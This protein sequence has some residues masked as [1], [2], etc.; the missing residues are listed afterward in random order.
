MF[1]VVFLVITCVVVSAHWYLWRRLVRDVSAPGGWWRRTGTV[2][3]F[4]MPALLV[5]AMVTTRSDVPFALQRTLAWPG[6]MWFAVVVYLLLTLLVLEVVRPLVLRLL[7]RR[8]A[9]RAGA[10]GGER[11]AAE[12]VPAALPTTGSAHSDSGADRPATS[13]AGH[14]EPAKSA[15]AAPPVEAALGPDSES[16]CGTAT[17][18]A[19]KPVTATAAPPAADAGSASDDPAHPDSPA[20]RTGSH[21]LGT[22]P[23]APGTPATPGDGDGPADASRRRFVARAAAITAGTVAAMTV[24]AGTH[25]VLAAGPKVKRVDVTLAKL[26]PAADGYRITLI[27]DIHMSPVIGRGVTERIVERANA[28][29]PD[30]IA[31]AGDLVDGQ[32]KNLRGAA[33]PLGRLRAREGVFF[34]TGNHEYYSGYEEWNAHLA[35]ALGIRVL[36][37]EREELRHFDIVGVND[38]AGEEHGDAPD[39]PKA[40]AGRDGKRPAVLIAHQPAMIDEAKQH[41]ID[42]QLSG[43]THGG[44]MFPGNLLAALANPT[45]VGL[46]RYGDTQLYVTRGAGAWGPPVRVGAEP[47]ITVLTLRAARS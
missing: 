21:L 11:P 8:D 4:A 32:V 36:R 17:A 19:D 15:E 6:L 28:T 20:G 2:L 25:S 41:G 38:L 37:N 35:G 42:L 7:R 33:R 45:L 30:L 47:D 22:S 18:V 29:D 14:T 5:A 9:R 3:A 27:S 1:V 13:V 31:I 23:P 16:A 44:Q 34:A 39:L 10:E 12:E 24:G 46:E 40:L 43:H 26:P